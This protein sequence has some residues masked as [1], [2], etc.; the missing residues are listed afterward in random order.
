MLR[1][2]RRL[3]DAI[4]A[5]KLGFIITGVPEEEGYG[6]GYGYGYGYGYPSGK[7][8]AEVE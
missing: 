7:R 2:L 3:L 4:P 1:E 6:L 8:L 5:A